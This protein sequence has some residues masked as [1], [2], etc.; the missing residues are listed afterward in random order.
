MDHH[1]LPSLSGIDTLHAS[2]QRIHGF[3]CVCEHV[4]CCTL[5]GMLWI[6]MCV[7]GCRVAGVRA[8]VWVCCALCGTTQGL[9]CGTIPYACCR[10]CTQWWRRQ[11]AFAR[12]WA[13][14]IYQTGLH[15]LQ[16]W[17]VFVG[18]CVRAPPQYAFSSC[19]LLMLYGTS[20]GSS[21][22]DHCWISKACVCVGVLC[23]SVCVLAASMCVASV[24]CWCV[25]RCD[26]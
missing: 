24:C 20:T 3:V 2:Q 21:S 14:V 15:V 6:W 17:R 1:P 12:L 5:A 13:V 22:Q 23:V 10:M 8:F 19:S 9:P 25:Q 18:L 16:C 11:G 4:S 26:V 7:L